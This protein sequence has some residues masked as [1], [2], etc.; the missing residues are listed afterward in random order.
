MSD[1]W[2]ECS[3]SG[4]AKAFCD[5]CKNG[6]PKKEEKPMYGDTSNDYERIGRVFEA[7]YAGTCTLDWDHKVR[8]GDRVSKVQRADNPMIPV[9][10][11]A[12]ASCTKV[13]PHAG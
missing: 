2:E 9:S 10:G 3:Y 4:L 11:V 7:Q 1:E 6:I 12:C 13:L 5:H 8:R